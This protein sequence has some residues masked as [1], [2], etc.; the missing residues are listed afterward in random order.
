MTDKIKSTVVCVLEQQEGTGF[1]S[2]QRHFR[3]KQY[4]NQHLVTPMVQVYS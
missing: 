3:F 1:E 4:I 2:R